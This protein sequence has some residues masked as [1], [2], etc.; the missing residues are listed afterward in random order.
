[1]LNLSTF[2]YSLFFQFDNPKIDDYSNIT[3]TDKRNKVFNVYIYHFDLL[4]RKY[5]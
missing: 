5:Y 4:A 3:W 1:M 2:Y